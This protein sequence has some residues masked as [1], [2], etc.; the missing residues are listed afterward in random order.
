MREI[1]HWKGIKLSITDKDWQWTRLDVLMES[2]NK[3]KI[4][5]YR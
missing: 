5:A 4:E 1:N 2:M 3:A